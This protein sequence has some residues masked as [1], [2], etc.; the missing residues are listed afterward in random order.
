MHENA[1]A[2][3]GKKKRAE[4][5][6]RRR[7]ESLTGSPDYTAGRTTQDFSPTGK[8]QDIHR[9]PPHSVQAEQGVLGSILN[10]KRKSNPT[11]AECVEKI[12]ADYFFTPAHQTIFTVLVEL[13][14]A[15]QAID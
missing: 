12:N 10:D 15:A 1:N 3:P 11:I 14:N 5:Q 8:A 2:P 6:T 9:T 7:G 13:W 4:R